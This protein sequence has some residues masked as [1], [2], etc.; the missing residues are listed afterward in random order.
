MK[1][2][3]ILLGFKAPSEK[4]N[5][6]TEDELA[7]ELKARGIT[8]RFYR[9]TTKKEIAEFLK[10]HPD[11]HTLVLTEIIGNS[12]YTENEFAD[13]TDEEEKNVIPIISSSHRQDTQYLSTLY[14]AGITSALFQSA[15]EGPTY[16][17]IAALITKKRS[18]K[19]AREAYGISIKGTT[20]RTLTYE[21]YSYYFLQLINQEDGH[22]NMNRLL[23]IAESLN[24][25]QLVDFLD[26][27]PDNVRMPLY[28]Y[29]E[30][31]QLV[32]TLKQ[33]GLKVK[34]YKKPRKYKHME[35]DLSF[36]RVA[37]KDT[38]PPPDNKKKK[39]KLFQKKGKEEV[40][41]H[42]ELLEI[43]SKTNTPENLE[44]NVSEAKEEIPEESI[45][46]GLDAV[47]PATASQEDTLQKE[48][49][50]TFI[51][52]TD[53]ETKPFKHTSTDKGDKEE[54]VQNSDGLFF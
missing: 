47:V 52:E 27:L 40:Q 21:A 11:C 3:K 7:L 13:F 39:K 22:S 8:P 30:F 14:A 9:R 37:Q 24:P 2:V 6:K 19:E 20:I 10:I 17:E 25:Y 23:H 48:P 35:D 1:P 26:K 41:D 38:A 12:T 49:T 31:A 50:D 43:F 51:P 29:V 33:Y 18:R 54:R 44:Q 34:H 36:Q 4:E 15:K 42:T 53:M 16:Q 32:E 46:D 28:D 5:K 45:L